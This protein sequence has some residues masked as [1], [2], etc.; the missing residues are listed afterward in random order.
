MKD[1]IK[2]PLL[3]EL[4]NNLPSGI[5]ICDAS[6]NFV[7]WNT[8]AKNVISIEYE[9]SSTGMWQEYYSALRMDGT[10]Y[11]DNEYPIM[12]AVLSGEMVHKERMLIN[13]RANN[14]YSYLEVDAFPVRDANKNIIAGVASFTD[15]TKNLKLESL[16]DE[17]TAQFEHLKQL[18]TN[19]FFK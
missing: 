16:V 10:Y 9:I 7:L 5:I 18:I 14:S 11:E 17:I 2:N 1:L 6:G 19:N 4:I 13:N 3:G 15:I 12:R 8:A